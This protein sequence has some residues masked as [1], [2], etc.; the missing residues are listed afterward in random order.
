MRSHPVP[1]Y[2]RQAGDSALS[3]ESHPAWRQKVSSEFTPQINVP[4]VYKRILSDFQL[5]WAL[6][7]HYETLAFTLEDEELKTSPIDLN[8]VYGTLKVL[9]DLIQQSEDPE[10]MTRLDDTARDLVVTYEWFAK[11]DEHISPYE[12]RVYLERVDAIEEAQLRA[13]ARY[14]LNKKVPTVNDIAKTDYLLAR[15]F[16]WIDEEGQVRINVESADKLEA[17]IA[18]LLPKEWRNKTPETHE[19]AAD[20]LL[21]FIFRLHSINSYEELVASG[22]IGEAR[23]FKSE[24][25]ENLYS[26]QVLSKCIMLN[27]ELRNRFERFYREE[28]ELLKKFSQTLIQSNAELVQDHI[29]EHSITPSSALEFSEQSAELLSSDYSQTLPYLQGLTQ[30][31]ELVQRTVMLYG[32]DP[33][34]APSGVINIANV[35]NQKPT[36]DFGYIQNP[37]LQ[38]RLE[39]INEM[40]RAIKSRPK[41][42]AVKILNLDNSTLVLS[43]WEFDAFNPSPKDSYFARLSNDLL[44]KSVALIAEIQENLALYRQHEDSPQ[45]ANT[46]LMKINF[47]VLQAQQS[48]EEL[49][50]QS[51]AAR[52]RHDID[53][54][55]NLSATRQKLLDSYN[56]LKPIL[57]KAAR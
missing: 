57:E 33:H 38:N 39:S 16:S 6:K 14:F 12:L 17:A 54:A 3:R 19:A 2:D 24:L 4:R 10:L 48:A 25:G 29:G 13:F 46:Y 45:L 28:N 36:E 1:C 18:R 40:I 43:S 31:R 23:Q 41:P 11:L 55:C 26:T 5:I 42:S 50:E 32:L 8:R 21:K 20:Q 35:L 15:A 9:Y 27:V 22:L 44:K 52:E 47:H 30:I 37:D 53:A 51:D 56:R 7:R 49:A 34:G